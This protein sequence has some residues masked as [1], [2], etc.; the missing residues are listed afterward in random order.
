MRSFVVDLKQKLNSEWIRFPGIKI[1]D[2]ELYFRG[3]I[4][5]RIT[6]MGDRN[7][8]LSNIREKD[9]KTIMQNLMAMIPKKVL[10]KLNSKYNGLLLENM[11]SKI[12]GTF[13]T[14]PSYVKSKV[15]YIISGLTNFLCNYTYLVSHCRK[16]ETAGHCCLV[17]K[18]LVINCMSIEISI[19]AG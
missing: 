5:R 14:P 17:Q 7:G 18:L 13:N 10:E 8:A 19:S 6:R 1:V 15:N 9:K 16:L 4:V 12:F 2:G 3:F 11:N